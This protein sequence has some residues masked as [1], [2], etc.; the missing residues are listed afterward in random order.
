MVIE[1]GKVMHP[2]TS[3]STK[4]GFCFCR[5]NKSRKSVHNLCASRELVFFFLS[6]AEFAAVFQLK[7][8][9]N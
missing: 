1:R 2:S 6:D 3:I 9:E 4:H 7:R 8:D 5:C